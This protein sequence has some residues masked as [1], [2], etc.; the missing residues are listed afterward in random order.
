MTLFYGTTEPG[1]GDGEYSYGFKVPAGYH[2]VGTPSLWKPVGAGQVT[3]NQVH[4]I[5]Q[6]S[7]QVGDDENPEYR[8]W[9]NEVLVT[10]TLTGSTEDPYK[11]VVNLWAER[12][13]CDR[14]GD[15]LGNLNAL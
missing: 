2:I 15:K 14:D 5:Q 9:F 10:Y 6:D 13:P 1:D 11:V 7:E 12:I 4:Y 3:L 8:G